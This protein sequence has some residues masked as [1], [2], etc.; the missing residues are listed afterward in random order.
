MHEALFYKKN[1]DQSVTCQLCRHH[2]RIQ[3][4]QRGICA[5]RENRD[6]R[7]YSLVYGR[8]IAQHV[9]PIEKKPLY[10]VLPGTRSYSIATV[11][12]NF[13][14]KNCQ[15]AD[16]SQAARE[17]PG[18]PIPGT[19]EEIP[20][21]RIV[22]AA[23]AA[24]CHSIAY[25]YTEPTIFFEYAL[26]VAKKAHA[27]G[28]KNVF[29]TNGYISEDPLRE[30]APVL[31]AANI[32]LKGFTE[33]FYHKICAARLDETLNSIR[34]Y[35]KLGIW[36]EIT[37]LVIPGLNDSD[38]ELR[39]I[40]EFIHGISPDI[41]W[42]VSRFHPDYQMVDR[43]VTP[44]ETLLRAQE[45]SREVG[46]NYVY[47]GNVLG[48]GETTVCPNCAEILVQRRGFAM[49]EHRLINGRCPRCHSFI[50]GIWS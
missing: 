12:C 10:H 31:D 47:V 33:D 13:R 8:L 43:G 21:D 9:D 3:V 17:H 15:N 50:P 48:L 46:L 18:Q 4:G 22:E 25:T 38:D 32:D 19:R 29:V 37:T 39:G 35:Y 1:E 6:G 7:L 27:Q 49:G 34:L 24:A 11:G 20:A 14:C 42:H 45:I 16:I 5:V 40:A 2:C 30:I 41:P 44:V 23:K 36:I 26:E 28:L